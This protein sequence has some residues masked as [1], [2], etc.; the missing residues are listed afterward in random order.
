M[1]WLKRL[2]SRRWR[3]A[4]LSDEI[5]EHLEEK[6]DDLV[7]SGLSRD[8]A[9]HAAQREFGNVTLVQ[10]DGRAVWR[11][12]AIEDLAGD[13]RYGLRTLSKNP[14]FVLV[15]VLTLALGIGVN[16]A[17]FTIVNGVLLQPLPFPDAS[18]L[19]LISY[20]A[21][22][23]RFDIGPSLSD[24]HYLEFRNQDRLFEHVTSFAG[25]R[26]TLT[27]AGDPIQIPVANV[28]T[29]FFSVLRT[30]PEIG[31]GFLATENEPGRDDV[32]VLGSHLW[33]L[34]FSGDPQIVGKTIRLDGVA[35]TVVGIMPAAF[36][37]PHNAQAWTPLSVRIDEHNS[38]SRPVVGRLKPGVSRQQA[39]AEFETLAQ[40]LSADRGQDRKS[41]VAQIIPLKEFVVGNVRESLV[42]FAGAVGFVLLIACA[43]VANLFLARAAHRRKEIGLRSALG[44]SRWR[45]LRQLLAESVL[46]SLAGG[47]AG[48]LLSFW[49]VPA[50]VALAPEGRIPRMEM[51]RVDGYVLAFTFGVSVVTAIAFG[52]APAL[53][54]TRRDVR[55]SLSQGGRGLTR[56]H[57]A[58]R[59][60]LA[61]S[62]IALALVLLAGAGLMLKSFLRLRAVHP[63]FE[64]SNVMIMTVDLPD[65]TYQTATQL[66]AFHSRT[67]AELLR[68]PGVRT[69]GAVNFSPLG[70][71]LVRGDFRVMGGPALPPGYVV[72]KPCVSAGYLRAMG[73]PVLRGR[74][75]SE[76]DNENAPGVA[77]VSESVA[78][79]LWPGENP[80]GKRIALEDEPKPGDWLSVVGVVQDVKQ[81]GLSKTADSAIYQPY[82]QVTRPFFLS[83]MSFVVKAEASA[84]ALAPAM[85]SVLRD[86]DGELPVQSIAAMDTVVAATTAEPRFQARLLG[87]FAILALGLAIVGIYGVLAYSVAQRTREIG[88][89]MALGAQRASVFRMLLRNALALAGTGI[90]IGAAGALAVTRVLTNFLFEVKPSDPQVLVMVAAALA[91][92]AVLACYVPARRAMGVDPITALREE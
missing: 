17:V 1:N 57:E 43:N 48:I 65:S 77:I 3:Y 42:V 24:R 5:R 74:D 66:R 63:G 46:V 37:F 81:Q 56:R 15:A 4:E 12:S 73:I 38:F 78:Q 36:D 49:G 8:E 75:F 26:S 50:L 87:A 71:F 34:R 29:D 76:G 19:F 25:T 70:E 80:L 72:D 21:L 90:A 60:V 28:T 88:V 59:S 91:G 2:F 32:V 13:V 67:L 10:E 89:R 82:L 40:R 16:T 54:A 44:A 20:S 61:V 22:H 84:E 45:L 18:R 35:R 85:R 30:N 23:G 62:E 92:A 27:G 64:P 58:V 6:V 47:V 41:M 55:D 39:Q 52:L 33:K 31:R 51:I 7:V 79:N 14:G 68:L 86:V 83:H 9:R 11:W 53:Q 69:A